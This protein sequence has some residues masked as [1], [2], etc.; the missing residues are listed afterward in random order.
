MPPPI[1]LCCVPSSMFTIKK[2]FRLGLNVRE[3]SMIQ[4]HF[5]VHANIIVLYCSLYF[6]EAMLVTLVS[7]FFHSSTICL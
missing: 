3:L 7:M 4:K 6:V 5:V 2:L 1:Q